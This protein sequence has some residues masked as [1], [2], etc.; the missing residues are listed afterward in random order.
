MNED[1]L[2]EDQLL[3]AADTLAREFTRRLSRRRVFPDAEAIAR[4]KKFD[5]PLPDTG[6]GH[7][8]LRFLNEFGSPATVASN[9]GHYYGFVIGASLPAAAA[10]ERLV[11]AWNQNALN[12]DSS[13]AA[14]AIERVAG[15]WVL[16]ALDLPRE[17]GVG[18]GTD[19]TTCTLTALVAARRELLTRIGWDIDRQGVVGSPALRVVVPDTVHTT[20][21]KALRVLGFG[22]ENI[23][24][25]P[26]D[27]H[28]R[29]D[30][31]RLPPLDER[32]ILILQAGELRAGVFD[33]FA[34]I[35]PR[36][37][38]AGTWVHIDGAF[39]LW[40]RASSHHHLAAGVEG[41]DSWSTDAHKSLA[42][43]YD[44]AMVIVRDATALEG[45]M[46]TD[47]GSTGMAAAS[48]RDLT[49]E[50]SRRP[51]GIGVW[52]V[53]NTLGRSGLRDLIDGY[54]RVAQFGANALAAA[55]FEILL[56]VEFNQILFRGATDAETIALVE[57][58]RSSG[59]TWFSVAQW[60]DRLAVRISVSSWRTR[61]EEMTALVHT[62]VQAQHGV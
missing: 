51:R 7:D 59:D 31:R 50:H 53:L 17:A 18:F 12:G 37:R 22:L 62:L 49:L 19:A 55:G 45:A 6:D 14:D 42:V 48:Q 23:V 24:T 52:A 16:E 54:V 47:P 13:P 11:L 15:R 3:E 39:G 4:L 29:V 9:G 43:P 57:A 40:A 58:A 21:F 36:A 60:Q 28:G 61:E 44:S 26:T 25:A 56:D 1:V 30:P 2:N 38:R 32:T 20:V 33:P 41:A 46:R 27:E 5:V 10:A 34:T 35:I 8:T